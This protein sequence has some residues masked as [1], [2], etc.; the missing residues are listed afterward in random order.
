MPQHAP[1]RTLCPRH[2]LDI[3]DAITYLRS[4]FPLDCRRA[5]ASLHEALFELQLVSASVLFLHCAA[6]ISSTRRCI[7]SRLETPSNAV[8][9][10]EFVSVF[11]PV[12]GPVAAATITTLPEAPGC[13][14]NIHPLTSTSDTKEENKNNTARRFPLSLGKNLL[15][16][17]PSETA[18]PPPHVTT[19][20]NFR[21]THQRLGDTAAKSSLK[22][23]Q[24]LRNPSPRDDGAIFQK[25]HQTLRNSSP[26]DN[27]AKLLSRSRPELQVHF[28]L[29]VTPFP[30]CFQT[31][32][33][34]QL[35]AFQA[36]AKQGC[37]EQCEEVCTRA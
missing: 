35:T 1:V 34:R 13:G 3:E 6:E 31:S 8:L 23:H 14:H 26:R 29:V 33:D 19:E 12:I 20:P 30:K 7:S 4:N 28:R 18:G 15:P 11:I 36:A 5:V 10:G 21:R 32:I 17:D 16:E 37:C 27:S 24:R 22:S 9:R 25:T 2:T